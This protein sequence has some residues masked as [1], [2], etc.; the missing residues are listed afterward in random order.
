MNAS[1]LLSQLRSRRARISDF[2]LFDISQDEMRAI[3]SEAYL[4]EVMKRYQT[5]IVN[6]VLKETISVIAQWLT[7]PQSRRKPSLYIVGYPGTG[8]TTMMLAIRETMNLLHQRDPL[9]PSSKISE[10]FLNIKTS[11][12]INTIFKEDLKQ[13]RAI[14][15][16]YFLG[17]DD[18]GNE[19][20]VLL[21]HGNIYTPIQNLL[22]QR[23]ITQYPTIITSNL[24]GK[25]IR[26]RYGN[27]IA[28]RM[29]EMAL[30]IIL[31]FDDVVRDGQTEHFS[32]RNSL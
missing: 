16:C 14:T 19:S 31:D 20:K 27:R 7:S 17:I 15:N 26:N 22:E 18:L 32:Y 11:K 9:C 1:Q 29:N 5:F 8:K 4:Q 6:D 3:L 10:L 25:D 23:Y 24:N 12:E 30:P 21:E 28:D 2:R 13:Y